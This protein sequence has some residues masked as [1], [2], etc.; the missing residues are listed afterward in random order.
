VNDT[1]NDTPGTL[2]HKYERFD[3]A[4][5]L[6]VGGVPVSLRA[7]GSDNALVALVQGSETVNVDS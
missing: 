2:D 6:T 4:R 5:S 3:L 7:D 1:C